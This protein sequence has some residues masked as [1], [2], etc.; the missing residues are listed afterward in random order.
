[1]PISFDRN[2]G[3]PHVDFEQ[4]GGSQITTCNSKVRMFR[5]RGA[6]GGKEESNPDLVERRIVDDDNKLKGNAGVFC[7]SIR[8]MVTMIFV[9]HALNH[10]G[11][12]E[13]PSY[14]K[15]DTFCALSFGACFFSVEI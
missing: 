13:K 14:S 7:C 3:L 12:L 4:S 10:I 8:T 5:E 6:G 2:T 9:K 15:D 11:R 1:M